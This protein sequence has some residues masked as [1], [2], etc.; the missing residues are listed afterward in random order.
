MIE[1]LRPFILVSW[2]GSSTRELPADVDELYRQADLP[3]DG[4]PIRL[5][6]LGPDGKLLRA[7]FPFAGRSPSSLGFDQQRMGMFLKEEIDKSTVGLDLAETRKADGAVQL[8]GITVHQ[9]DIPA[10]MP[11]GARILLRLKHPFGNA[12]RAPVVETV[13]N[14]AAEREALQYTGSVRQVAANSLERWFKQ[15]YPP[16][17]M[18]RS[19][20]VL[21]VSG[22][23]TMAPAGQD[24][25]YCYS[26]L[27]GRVMFTFDDARRTRYEGT[28][29]VALRYRSDG[30]ALESFRGIYRGIFPRV[31]RQGRG[32]ARILM[33]A[34]LESCGS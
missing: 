4:G 24:A 3:R 27:Q 15:L 7:F 22:K 10:D 32:E 12:Y 18:E 31:D 8:P 19:G 20:K 17:M 14:T 16:G 1:A 13:A 28:V 9:A 6:V 5:F 23:L 34:V 26:I 2:N 21:A 29:A 25:Q 33:Q 30:H 11:A